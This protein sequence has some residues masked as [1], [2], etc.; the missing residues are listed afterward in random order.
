MYTF[1]VIGVQR[2]NEKSTQLEVDFLRL[3]IWTNIWQDWSENKRRHKHQECKE[4]HN[5]R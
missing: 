2:P 1:K 5:Y 4:E 3:E